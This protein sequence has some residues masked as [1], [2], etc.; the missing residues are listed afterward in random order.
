MSRLIGI[1]CNEPER[2]KQV[3]APAKESLVCDEALHG[4]GLAMFQGGEVLLQRHP[5][6]SAPVDFGAVVRELK[7]DYIIGN[8]RAAGAK[9]SP[10][11]TPPYRYKRWVFGHSGRIEG[12]DA[13]QADVL[14]AVPDFLRRN[15]R[16][17][18]ESEH[19]FHLLLAFLH[20]DG[21][22]DDQ[23]PKVGDAENAIRAMILMT[24]QLAATK[25]AR[26]H[27]LNLVLT[28]GRIFAAARRGPAMWWRRQ[29][30]DLPPKGPDAPQLQRS[31]LI[32]SEPSHLP[33][34]GFE[35][36]PDGTIVTVTRD[37]RTHIVPVRDGV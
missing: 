25:G 33:T 4:W 13:I 28:N 23:E 7:S 24:E 31:V 20:D 30:T 3:V 35:E 32:V 34:E 12:F 22:L 10:E 5:K 2:L 6:P 26:V 14:S 8:V 18:T 21:K 19:L 37:F 11:N 1:V 9:P 17:Q 29:H 16:G 36:I 27:G 15:I